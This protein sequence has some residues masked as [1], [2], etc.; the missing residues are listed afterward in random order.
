MEDQLSSLV[1]HFS[2]IKDPRIDRKKLHN[3]SEILVIA[4]CAILSGVDSWEHI[5]EFGE[6]KIDWFKSF[7]TLEYGI[8]SHDT[9]GR[10]FS[11]LSPEE[12]ESCF[13]SW[14]QNAVQLLTGEIIPIDGKRLRGS[15]DTSS[16]KAAIHMV[17]AYASECGL[18][19]GQVKT[20]D[21]SNEITAIPELL[22]TLY[23]KG[24]IVTIDAMGCQRNIA[25][26]IIEAEAD[27]VL[28]LKGNQGSLHDDVTLYLNDAHKKEF[29]NIP[30]DY[31]ETVEKNHGRIEQ[32]K[33]WITENIHWIESKEKWR[34][35]NSI[36]LVESTRIIGEDVSTEFRY[37][38][39]SI[40]QNA[41][42]FANAVRA[43]WGIENKVHW[44]LDVTF[45]EDQ[46]R[47]RE[48]HSAHNMSILR[49][50]ALNILKQDDSKGSI[51]AKRLRAGWK[52][53]FLVSLLAKLCNF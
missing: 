38:I 32:R 50:F 29:K 25:D 18:V 14:V 34:G 37:Y 7:L 4:I 3:L 11:L 15:Y 52:Q 26:K 46:H 8:P 51:K 36:G 53:D 35:L 20:E 40:E 30:H 19:L 9:F 1:E 10:V 47:T 27:Y 45:N 13:V 28:A 12:L 17:S 41:E 43:H 16:N 48:G 5:A 23:I 21:K 49:R 31:Y 24:C 39:C 44:I 22:K 6:A 2:V 33:Y 42:K